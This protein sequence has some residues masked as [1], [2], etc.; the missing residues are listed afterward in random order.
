MNK[1]SIHA[2]SGLALAVAVA[3]SGIGAAELEEIIVTAQ[4]RA[5]SLQDVPMSMSAISGERI[6][7]IG[8]FSDFVDWSSYMAGNLAPML[9]G[10]GGAGF[11]GSNL[12]KLLIKN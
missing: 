6:E 10:T 2:L 1:K 3:S 12:I 11:V 4:K 9:L 5:E 8:G 7:D